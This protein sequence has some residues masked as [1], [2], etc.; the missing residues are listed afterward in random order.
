MFA[1]EIRSAVARSAVRG[2][3]R[4][5]AAADELAALVSELEDGSLA[6]DPV[7]AVECKRLVRDVVESALLNSM[8]APEDL[9]WRVRRIRSRLQPIPTRSLSRSTS[10]RPASPPSRDLESGGDGTKRFRPV[11]TLG[12]LAHHLEE[13]AQSLAVDVDLDVV[14]QRRG[15]V[16]ESCLD[17]AELSAEVLA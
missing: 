9:R 2:E 13:V 7:A 1:A 12:A 14:A 16:V 15:R 4:I 8:F 5:L 17:L 11:P 6:L 3:P 10:R